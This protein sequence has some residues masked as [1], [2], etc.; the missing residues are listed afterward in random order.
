MKKKD[1]EKKF[2]AKFP[3]DISNESEHKHTRR[4]SAPISIEKKEKAKDISSLPSIIEEN[5]HPFKSKKETPPHH[6]R[7]FH[8]STTYE[9]EEEIKVKNRLS[10]AKPDFSLNTKENKK[11]DMDEA[12]KN[13]R[14]S[15][16]KPSIRE[17]DSSESFPVTPT[18]TSTPREISTQPIYAPIPSGHNVEEAIDFILKN[19]KK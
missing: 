17:S 16:E 15:L 1:P 3:G 5:N 11:F 19:D 8:S 14:I 12:F 13:L 2:E 7:K 6:H 4:S 18:P 9:Q 10:K